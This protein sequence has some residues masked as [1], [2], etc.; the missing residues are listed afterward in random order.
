MKFAW[1][2]SRQSNNNSQ[3]CLFESMKGEHVPTQLPLIE[4]QHFFVPL[5]LFNPPVSRASEPCVGTAWSSCICMPQPFRPLASLCVLR[6]FFVLFQHC[7]ILIVRASRFR[8]LSSQCAVVITARLSQMTPLDEHA[9]FTPA[10]TM[11]AF[12]SLSRYVV[13]TFESLRFGG[14]SRVW[15]SCRPTELSM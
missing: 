2:F 1:L 12:R 5:P 15:K 6:A 10:I 4:N 7:L 11:L 8:L 13:P 9:P 3:A 14:L